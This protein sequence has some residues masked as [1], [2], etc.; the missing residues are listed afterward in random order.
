MIVMK[1]SAILSGILSMLMLLCGSPYAASAA[2]DDCG[3]PVAQV[4]EGCTGCHGA[5]PA[6]GQHGKH[7]GNTRCYRCH[8]TVIDS[9]FTF[10]PT[11]LHNNG[12]V[13]YAVGCSSCHGWNQGVSPPQNLKGECGQGLDGV[14]AHKAMRMSAIP[15]HQVA[16]SN[17]HVVPLSLW[18]SG[19][20]NGTVEVRF[21]GLAQ[22]GGAQPVWNGSTCKNVYCHGA[23]LIGGDYKEPAW[24]DT[25]GAASRCGA[26]HR[27]AD[28]DNNTAADCSSCHPGTVAPDRSILP[29]GDHLNGVID[30]AGAQK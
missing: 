2:V 6:K 23:T 30:T 15:V 19:H 3:Y 21:S 8:G 10:L 7:P 18:A 5:P 9:N 28:P 1:I 24:R 26:C 13:D 16:C 20:D 11:Q 25:S 29:F 27:L 14:G 12:T 22:A 4:P 17:C